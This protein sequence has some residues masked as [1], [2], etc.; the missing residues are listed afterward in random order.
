MKKSKKLLLKKRPLK[1]VKIKVPNQCGVI[2]GSTKNYAALN[3]T[4]EAALRHLL[5]PQA[6]NAFI[7]L[8]TSETTRAHFCNCCRNFEKVA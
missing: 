6:T 8:R 1:I 3:F 4:C 2:L 7:C 5:K